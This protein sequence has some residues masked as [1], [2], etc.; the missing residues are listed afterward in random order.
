MNDDDA[1]ETPQERM[2]KA[3]LYLESVKARMDPEDFETLHQ[4]VQEMSRLIAEGDEGVLEAGDREN[5]GGD[6]QRS[7]P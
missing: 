1:D 2:A 3:E 6:V 4:A 5:F 7:W